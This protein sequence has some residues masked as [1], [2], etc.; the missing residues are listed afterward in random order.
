[1]NRRSFLC[2]LVAAPAIV[3]FA[4]LMPVRGIIV[5]LPDQTGL[6][7]AD[8]QMRV[9]DLMRIVEAMRAAGIEDR[10]FSFTRWPASRL[11]TAP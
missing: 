9:V 4:S 3:P 2:G 7:F 5:A 11:P 10:F 6:R 1:M 8:S